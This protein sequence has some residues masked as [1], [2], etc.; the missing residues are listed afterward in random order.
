ML[1]EAEIRQAMAEESKG[2]WTLL[3][4]ESGHQGCI[5]GSLCTLW[6]IFES[7]MKI[8]ESNTCCWEWMTLAGVQGQLS[9]RILPDG[10]IIRL[11]LE[12]IHKFLAL[13]DKLHTACNGLTQTEYE[14]H[15]IEFADSLS[16]PQKLADRTAAI[17][18]K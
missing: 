3:Y 11:G 12:D 10:N 1:N 14:E 18:K 15:E 4:S 13:D 8:Q 5:N 7:A 16:L 9:F 2:R 17:N 6:S